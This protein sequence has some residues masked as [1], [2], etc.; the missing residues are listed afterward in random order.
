MKRSPKTPVEPAATA[1]RTAVLPGLDV[2]CAFRPEYL[3]FQRGIHVGNLTEHERITRILKLALEARYRQP[4]VTE[5]WGRG[6]Y[7]RWIGF[8]ARAN[9]AAKPLSSAV[10]FGCAKFF[11]MVDTDDRAVKFGMQIERG[12]EKP[13]RDQRQ[14]ALK[15]DWDWH[16]LLAALKARGALAK[17]LERLVRREDFQLYAGCWGAESATFTKA[18]YPGPSRLRAILASASKNHWAGFQVFYRMEEPDVK[19]A[20]GLDLVEAMLAAYQELV[21]AMNQCMQIELE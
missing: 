15:S 3:D 1:V 20:T 18:D 12:I 16:R 11:L 14:F 9:R 13:T 4:F 5:R 10:S 2:P 7:W 6:V 21:P 19:T 17:E 8:L